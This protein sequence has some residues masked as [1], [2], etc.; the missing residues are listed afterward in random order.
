[1]R[2]QGA[3]SKKS[4]CSFFQPCVEILHHGSH[5]VVGAKRGRR[6][7]EEK[8]ITKSLMLEDGERL[9]GRTNPAGEKLQEIFTVELLANAAVGIEY[10]LLWTA[11]GPIVKPN[12]TL[13]STSFS[14]FAAILMLL[15]A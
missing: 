14:T 12:T 11:I 3:Y 13:C 8:C 5:G 7:T 9:I 4:F 1:M 10:R 15:K 2:G 6:V